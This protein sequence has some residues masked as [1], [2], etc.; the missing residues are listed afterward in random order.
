M[1]ITAARI[2]AKIPIITENFFNYN[3]L[4]IIVVLHITLQ[5]FARWLPGP[6][7]PFG[8]AAAGTFSLLKHPN[9]NR[10]VN[11]H[12]SVDDRKGD[13][14]AYTVLGDVPRPF[15]YNNFETSLYICLKTGLKK[16]WRV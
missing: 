1:K 7:S 14:A 5:V 2:N 8:A 10:R 11:G 12:L 9:S 15:H 16:R 6:P 4:L 13:G 3:S